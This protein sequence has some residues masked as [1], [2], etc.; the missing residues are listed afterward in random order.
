M[1]DDPYNQYNFVLHGDPCIQLLWGQ[2]GRSL[3]VLQPK[4]CEIIEKSSDLQIRWNAAGIGF[5][6]DETIKLEYSPD[7]G[8][9][10]H[11]VPGAGSLPHNGSSFKWKQCPLPAGPNYRIRVVSQVDAEASAVSERDFTIGDLA[12]LIVQSSPVESV[13]VDL[14]GSKTDDCTLV[15]DF[16]ITIL[17]GASVSLSA[18]VVAG[19]SSEFTFVRWKDEGGNTITTTPDYTFTITQDKT[20]VAE[21][22][23]P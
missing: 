11:R 22:A 15:T 18:P 13:T 20:I 14:S 12:R 21:Y 19:D 2:S 9:T 17:E 3:Q 4:G 7:S 8:Q 10:W 16:D 23:G 1:V 5:S 6:P